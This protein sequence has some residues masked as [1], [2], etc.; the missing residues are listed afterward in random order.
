[1][2]RSVGDDPGAGA[3]PDAGPGAGPGAGQTVAMASTA[4]FVTA[5]ARQAPTMRDA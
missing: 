5:T 2:Q 4:I 3:G 1:H